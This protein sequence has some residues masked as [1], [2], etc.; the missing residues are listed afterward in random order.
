MIVATQ[1]SVIISSRNI[2]G[3]VSI[4]VNRMIFLLICLNQGDAKFPSLCLLMLTFQGTSP[5]GAARQLYWYLWIRL[6]SIFIVIVSQLLKQ[7]LLE[8]SYVSWRKVWRWSRTYVPS[9]ECLEHQYMDLLTC[10]VIKRPS[11]IIPS[12]K[13]LY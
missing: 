1:E 2:T 6:P 3:L 11:T 10:Y 8:Q 4:G 12:K 7:V 13:S 5:T 9:Y